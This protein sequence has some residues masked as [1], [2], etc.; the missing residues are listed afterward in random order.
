MQISRLVQTSLDSHINDVN[1]RI[2]NYKT[3]SIRTRVQDSFRLI[4]KLRQSQIAVIIRLP[5]R[6]RHKALKY[7]TFDRQ[8]REHTQSR[9]AG[10]RDRKEFAGE[11]NI[12]RRLWRASVESLIALPIF[13]IYLIICFFLVR[14]KKN[15]HI[16]KF[17]NNLT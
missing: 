1:K 14:S 17:G 9:F 10:G 3:K 7:F 6:R 2:K 5:N 4:N 8:E 15:R 12:R 13:Y 16:F 11:R